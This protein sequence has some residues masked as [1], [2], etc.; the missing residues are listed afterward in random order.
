MIAHLFTNIVHNHFTKHRFRDHIG[1][2]PEVVLKDCGTKIEDK[3]GKLGKLKTIHHTQ[4]HIS[5]Q[6]LG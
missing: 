4:Q 1:Q 3:I 5:P 2:R 6:N